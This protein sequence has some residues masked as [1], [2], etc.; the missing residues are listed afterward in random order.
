MPVAERVA[1]TLPYLLPACDGYVYGAYIYQNTPVFGDIA[2]LFAPLVNAFESVP[3]GGLALFIGLS[4]FARS[5][6]LSRFVRFNIQQAIVLD[7]AL[8]I[9][10][11]FAGASRMFPEVLQIQGSNFVFYVWFF[12]C[13]YSAFCNLRGETPDQVPIISEAAAAQVGPF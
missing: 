4:I 2:L 7:I 1:A 8:V 6:N 11:L 3:F 5:A 9:P 12:T 10:S 13:A